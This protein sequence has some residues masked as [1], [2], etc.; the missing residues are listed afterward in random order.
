MARKIRFPLEMDDGIKVRN[1][2][3]LREHFSITKVMEHFEDG[4]LIK[5]LRNCYEDDMADKIE[6][7]DIKDIKIAQKICE[8]LDVPFDNSFEEN[9]QDL[10]E[11]R[12]KL[13]KLE[14][15]D[16][17]YKYTDKVDYIAFD[18]DDL[19]D[20]LDDG[21]EE[22]YLLGDKFLIPLPKEGVRYIGI[23]NPIAVV[24]SKEEVDWIKKNISLVDI[25]YN[26]EYQKI[27][28]ENK[29]NE[30]NIGEYVPSYINFMLSDRDVNFSKDMYKNIKNDI[31]SIE[32]NPDDEVK[33]LKSIVC[34]VVG[35]GSDYIERISK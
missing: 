7:L 30:I 3:E 26:E 25:R 24:K 17:G 1:P 5:W 21:V 19:Y 20:L 9:M 27:V 8:I 12:E 4:K 31:L 28:D 23:N 22:I 29:K 14:S 33:E 6:E 11:R 32:Y 15:F 16:E 18:Q 13:K 34:E 35:L 2:E 10:E